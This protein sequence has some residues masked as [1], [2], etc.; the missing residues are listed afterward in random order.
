[1]FP[2]GKRVRLRH[3]SCDAHKPTAYVFQLL[4]FALFLRI[5]G[6]NRKARSEWRSKMLPMCSLRNCAPVC[7]DVLCTR[8]RWHPGRGTNS[9]VRCHIFQTGET[10]WPP[11]L[12][13]K[14]PY[15][16]NPRVHQS[17]LRNRNP[18][19]AR[20]AVALPLT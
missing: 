20:V 17:P 15:R 2:S 19:T 4:P 11:A 9:L 1:M 12:S 16:L 5:R 7:R 3:I 14:R 13:L 10:C 18:R 8:S 6:L